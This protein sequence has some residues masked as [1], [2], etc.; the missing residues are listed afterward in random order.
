STRVTTSQ[1]TKRMVVPG[2]RHARDG[3]DACSQADG[4]DGTGPGAR[5]PGERASAGSKD[6]W[7]WAMPLR[8]IAPGPGRSATPST[9][10]FPVPGMQKTEPRIELCGIMSLRFPAGMPTS[11]IR[12]AVDC[13][14]APALTWPI[15]GFITSGGLG[16]QKTPVALVLELVPDVSGVR[17]T[18]SGAWKPPSEG[19]QSLLV[20]RV[21]TGV[22]AP[23]GGVPSVRAPR[24][25]FRPGG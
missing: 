1:C 25:D 24:P 17:S 7:S 2:R 14:K 18:P 3:N 23:A 11:A 16:G 22:H 6:Q 4:N 9:A 19:G 8:A 10:G 5:P 13:P 15:V 20:M 21:P 12:C